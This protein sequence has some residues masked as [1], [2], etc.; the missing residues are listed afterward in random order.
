M[1]F[2]GC[3]LVEPAAP[4]PPEPS[5]LAPTPRSASAEDALLA[6]LCAARAS[7]AA[8]VVRLRALRRP[9]SPPIRLAAVR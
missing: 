8:D 1:A 4:D 6:A 2:A 5:M 3:G 9:Q 7:E